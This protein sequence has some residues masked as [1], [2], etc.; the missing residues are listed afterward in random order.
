MVIIEITNSSCRRVNLISSGGEFGKP[1][2]MGVGILFNFIFED[3]KCSIKL[4]NI[5]NS[6]NIF[7]YFQ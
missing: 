5:R 6:Q 7:E 4:E 1:Y 2:L 3:L